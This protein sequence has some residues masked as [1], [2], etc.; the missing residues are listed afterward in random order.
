MHLVTLG[1]LTETLFGLLP[2]VVAA[3]SGRPKPAPSL[4]VWLSL[5]AGIV[6]LLIGTALVN[7]ALLIQGGALVLLAAILLVDQLLGL[8][9]GAADKLPHVKFYVAGLL[10]FFVGIFVGTGM[11]LGWNTALGMKSPIEVHIHA[12]NWGLISMVLAGLM[13]D[14][15][16]KF[17]GRQVHW[18]NSANRVFWLMLIGALGLVAGPWLGSRP[19]TAIGLILHLVGTITVVLNITL[20]LRGTGLL[21][22][23]GY[24]H[25][26]TSYAW[27]LAPILFAPFVLFDVPGVLAARIE[28]SAPQALVYGWLLQIG[29]ALLPYLLARSLNGSDDAPLGGNVWSLIGIH[30]GSV[31]LWLGIFMEAQVGILHGLAYLIWALAIIPVLLQL[32]R[33]VQS[34]RLVTAPSSD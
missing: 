3:R 27:I 17:S 31:L 34:S 1:I 2:A 30:A 11:W 10:Y 28:A 4:A 25:L 20:P 22:Q 16:P 6:L 23:P 9:A 15:Y 13:F 18:P 8:R 12:N 14:L 32:V 7:S 5:T 21:R 33:I 19:I 29:L 26:I 24:L